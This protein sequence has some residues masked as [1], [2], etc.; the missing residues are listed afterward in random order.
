MMRKLFRAQVNVLGED[1]VEVVMSTAAVARDGHILIPQGCVLDNY[2]ANPI[3]LWSHD[4]NYPIGNAENVAI[5]GDKITARIRFAPLGISAKADEVRGLMKS[6]VVRAVSVGFDPVEMEP[7]NPNRPRG[8]QR[9]STWELL[10]LSPVSVP[11]D[12]GA[13][14]TA[15]AKGNSD[16]A[17][18]WKVGASRNLP[19]DDS[20]S[21][22]GP[23]A[24][25]SIFEWAGG[26]EFDPSK[27]RKGFLVY[28]ASKDDERGAYKLPIATVKDGRLTVPKGAIRAAA[29]RLPQTD[30][31]DDVK[32]R[33]QAVID[34]YKEKA[35]IGEDEKRSG[36]PARIRTFKRVGPLTL[37]RGLYEVANLCYLFECLGYHVDSAKFESAIEGD[38][39][40]VPAML[41]QVL[42]DLGDALIAMT[43]EEVEEALEGR[44]VEV[45][46]AD[47]GDD[48]DIL[49]VEERNH[50]AG[51]KTA[52][53]RSFRR[54]LAFAK[55][56]A[57]KVLSAATKKALQ[58]AQDMHADAMDMHR[59]AM[60]KHKQAMGA[61]DDMMNASDA[62]SAGDDEE[63]NNGESDD[64]DEQN[65]ASPNDRASAAYRKRQADILE[66]THT[67]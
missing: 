28:D 7:L 30:I 64:A 8:G 38:D 51:G 33:A 39:S 47:D 53:V 63:S 45:E 46:G 41:V 49:T 23:E 9:I 14:V 62:D 58:D 55:L 21:W 11:A 66:L 52:A 12:T 27:A 10:E 4:P 34:H 1:E 2:R 40:E 43:K 61:I 3:V 22:D 56:R 44:D 31:P 50:I 20:D 13:V 15:R 42:H 59:S 29:S 35:G 17:S 54:G 57:G 37:K 65:G 19:V 67:I 32:E 18:E 5:A 60:R 16:M 36:R 25:K 26:D 24:E 48:D 6:G